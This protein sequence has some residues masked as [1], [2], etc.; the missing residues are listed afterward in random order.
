MYDYG[1]QFPSLFI[2][3][4]FLK[5]KDEKMNYNKNTQKLKQCQMIFYNKYT[6][7]FKLTIKLV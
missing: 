1:P 6:K 2:N 5:T 3:N 4:L 7:L